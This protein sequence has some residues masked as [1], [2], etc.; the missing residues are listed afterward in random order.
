VSP[1]DQNEIEHECVQRATKAQEDEIVEEDLSCLQRVTSR[2]L[3]EMSQDRPTYRPG[4]RE[5]FD[6]LF[7]D[8]YQRIL[9]TLT[10][11]LRDPAAAEECAQEAFVR[12]YRSWDRWK[13]DAPAEAWVH[14]IALNVAISHRR[15][16][17]LRGLSEVITRK[18]RPENNGHDPEGAVALADALRR[19]PPRD[20]ALI[21]LR[22]HHGYSNREIAAALGSPE[23][24]VASRLAAAKRR[25]R[26]ELDW[27]ETR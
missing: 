12:A 10:G 20:A 3:E 4:V 9:F 27:D 1:A 13:P 6:Q 5:D 21:V 8:S 16:E 25:L 18:G 19:L 14:R 17:R 11:V 26:D 24:T 22:H 2:C 7:R 23:S 15:R